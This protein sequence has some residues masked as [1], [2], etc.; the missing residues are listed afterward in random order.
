MI[1]SGTQSSRVRERVTYKVE[2]FEKILI[3][4]EFNFIS[5]L[6]NFEFNIIN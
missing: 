4:L 1:E 2:F 6:S 5:K 3:E